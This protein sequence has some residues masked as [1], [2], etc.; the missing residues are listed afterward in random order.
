[1]YTC[2]KSC[3]RQ[4]K[5]GVCMH[6]TYA[7]CRTLKFSASVFLNSKCLKISSKRTH[8]PLFINQCVS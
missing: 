7:N 4:I 3:A 5:V 1:M 8:I 6:A 2:Q